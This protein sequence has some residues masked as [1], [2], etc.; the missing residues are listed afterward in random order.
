MLNL[1]VVD[2]L[3]I[4]RLPF[5]SCLPYQHIMLT[6]GICACKKNEEPPLIADEETSEN[7]SET[8]EPAESE[9]TDTSPREEKTEFYTNENNEDK[10]GPSTPIA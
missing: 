4:L 2:F 8:T 10:W 5:Y 3:C 6:V 7:V 1:L 9:P